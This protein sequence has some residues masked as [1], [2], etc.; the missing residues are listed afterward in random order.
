MILN[1][2][3]TLQ[4]F[5]RVRLS[6]VAASLLSTA[7]IL[8]VTAT[9]LIPRSWAACAQSIAYSAKITGSL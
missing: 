6:A 8:A 3:M 2:G 4:S 1:R 5:R 9:V 7:V